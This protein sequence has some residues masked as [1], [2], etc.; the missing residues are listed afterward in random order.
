MWLLTNVQTRMRM[1]TDRDTH[2]RGRSALTVAASLHLSHA[3]EGVRDQVGQSPVEVHRGQAALVAVPGRDQLGQVAVHG[4]DHPTD[5]QL[6]WGT[7][8]H[9]R[10]HAHTHTVEAF[11]YATHDCPFKL[12][13]CTIVQIIL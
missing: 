6:S 5:I 13:Y 12:C 2:T 11:S 8:T 10:T 9:T 3:V 7:R 4:L 1:H